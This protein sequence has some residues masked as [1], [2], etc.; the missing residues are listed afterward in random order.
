MR[1]LRAHTDDS[2]ELLLDTLCNVFGGIILITCLL[3]LKTGNESS[4]SDLPAVDLIGTRVLLEQRMEAAKSELEALQALQ[5]EIQTTGD[6]PWRLLAAERDA[7]RRTQE[8]LREQRDGQMN[9]AKEQATSKSLDP[10]REMSELR[11]EAE[12]FSQKLADANSATSAMLNKKIELSARIDRI[13]NEITSSEQLRVQQLRFPKE[14]IKNKDSVNLIM[15]F[16]E[17]FPLNGDH[18]GLFPG[19]TETKINEDEFLADPKKSEGLNLTR[20]AVLIRGVLAKCKTDGT[21]ISIIVY[22]EDESFAA[23]RELKQLIHES[24]V[25]YGVVVL[26]KDKPIPFSSKGRSPPPL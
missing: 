10:G 22:P 5:R 1:K 19:L 2:M 11:R 16:G 4:S 12:E 26:T 20:D 13:K 15:K 8:R 17:I 9:A 21:Y 18:G 6:T 24:M 23:F 7:L 25:D 14:K 3:A